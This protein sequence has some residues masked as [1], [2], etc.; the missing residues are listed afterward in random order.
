MTALENSECGE[1][2]NEDIETLE[3]IREYVYENNFREL[4]VLPL[5]STSVVLQ[6]PCL[7]SPER[8]LPPLFHDEPAVLPLPTVEEALFD[9]PSVHERDPT[10][11]LSNYSRTPGTNNFPLLPTAWTYEILPLKR[12]IFTGYDNGK[13]QNHFFGENVDLWTIFRAI[14]DDEM[15]S[16]MVTQTNIYAAQLQILPTIK[17]N[18]RITRWKDVSADEMLKFIGIYLFTGLVDFPTTECYWKKDRLYFH[19]FLHEISMSYD[20]FCLILRCWHFVDN[21]GERNGRLQNTTSY[22]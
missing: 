6:P 2:P 11:R 18:S 8:I 5:S 16:L 22:R 7:S 15:I 9:Q 12:E 17:P 13:R 4:P 21:T 19:P 20:R 10:H 1:L 14:V 3:D